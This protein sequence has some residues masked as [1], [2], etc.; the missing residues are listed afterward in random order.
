[1]LNMQI[2]VNEFKSQTIIADAIHDKCRLFTY[3]SAAI[4]NNQTRI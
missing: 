3:L 4:L 2:N 1:M